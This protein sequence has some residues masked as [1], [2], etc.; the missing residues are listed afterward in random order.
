[1]KLHFDSN[2]EYQL[3]AIKAVTDI[4]EGKPLNGGDFEFT[5]HAAGALLPLMRFKS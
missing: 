3:E 1:M 4:F 2:Q 5:V